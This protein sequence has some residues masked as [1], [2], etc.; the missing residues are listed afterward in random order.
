LLIAAGSGITPVLSIARTVLAEEPISDVTILLINRSVS[1]I[2]FR[3][4]I[5]EL[6]SDNFNRLSVH[7][8]LT[9]ERRDLELFDGRLDSDRLERVWTQLL[10]H[11]GIDQAYICGPQEMAESLRGKLVSLGLSGDSIHTE[12]FEVAGAARI[13]PARLEQLRAEAAVGGRANSTPGADVQIRLNGLEQSLLV[14]AGATVL[15]SALASGLPLPYAC[16]GGV[17]ATC[18]AHVDSGDVA[19][20]V[21]QALDDDEVKQGFVLTC[22]SEVTSDS[23]RIDFDRR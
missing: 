19:M 22:Q 3:D 15:E 21:N 14:P 12:L 5:D 6:K 16:A 20:R 10:A 7:H 9:R 11:A 18:R 23:A 1:T 8:F 13:D 17:C 2:M 4:E